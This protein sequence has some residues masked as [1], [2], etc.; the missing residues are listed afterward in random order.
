MTG[1]HGIRMQTAIRSAEG[2]A[3]A[4]DDDT[5]W[6]ALADVP[7][8]QARLAALT[9]R[10]RAVIV[11]RYY[12]DLS[13]QDVAEQL[14]ISVGTVKSTASRALA[15]LGAGTTG[16]HLAEVADRGIPEPGSMSERSPR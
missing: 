10:Q 3:A 7:R 11:L 12:V 1:T 13:E 2:E 8:W 4:A 6:R 5:A 9:P 14:G 16:Q 15:A